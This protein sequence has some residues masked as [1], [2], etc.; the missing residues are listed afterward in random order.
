MLLEI[1][2]FKT[3]LT[4]CGSVKKL[5]INLSFKPEKVALMIKSVCYEGGLIL[6]HVYNDSNSNCYACQYYI[7][8]FFIGHRMGEHDLVALSQ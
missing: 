3:L 2:L 8:H 6:H 5:F 1:S 4:S 7:N